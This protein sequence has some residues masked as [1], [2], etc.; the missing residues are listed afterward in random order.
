[1]APHTQTHTYT[2]ALAKTNEHKQTQTNNKPLS[3]IYIVIIPAKDRIYFKRY[4]QS[5]NAF[6]VSYM[7]LFSA[8]QTGLCASEPSRMPLC[9]RYILF[10][11]SRTVYKQLDQ[12]MCSIEFSILQQF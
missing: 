3:T 6:P 5:V 8:D 1:M 7:L 12:V 2:Y 4:Q 9:V 11:C 10:V